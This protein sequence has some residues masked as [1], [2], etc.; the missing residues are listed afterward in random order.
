[1]ERDNYVR[2]VGTVKR[3]SDANETGNGRSALDFTLVVSGIGNERPT[4][5][6][7]VAYDQLIVEQQLEGFVEA[8]EV[9]E[10]EGHLTF[11]S[12]TKP[13]GMMRSGL[14]VY[15]DSVEERS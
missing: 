8:G 6:D 9:L 14:V 4:Y 13:N 2:L 12:Y 5:V 3:D 10:V 15:V 11:R 1:M 7:C